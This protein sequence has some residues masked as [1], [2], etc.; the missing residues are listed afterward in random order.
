MLS[1]TQIH[2][3]SRPEGGEAAVSWMSDETAD[4]ILKFA[5]IIT[6]GASLLYIAGALTINLLLK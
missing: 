6:A 4:F 5:P 3:L 2:E 1:T